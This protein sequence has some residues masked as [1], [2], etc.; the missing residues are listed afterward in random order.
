MSPVT[1]CLLRRRIAKAIADEYLAAVDLDSPAALVAIAKVDIE[2][3]Q[4][5][6]VGR[7]PDPGRRYIDQRGQ[8]PAQARCMLPHGVRIFPPLLLRAWVS[9]AEDAS[10]HLGPET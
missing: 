4:S 1:P 5:S 10:G 7:P 2:G 8:Q 6:Q 9:P 3:T